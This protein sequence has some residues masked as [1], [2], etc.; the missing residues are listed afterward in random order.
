MQIHVD[1]LYQEDIILTRKAVISSIVNTLN[2]I[3]IARYVYKNYASNFYDDL[4]VGF[5]NPEFF[6]YSNSV[7]MNCEILRS[8]VSR[9]V[10]W[11]MMSI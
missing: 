4:H 2:K 5:Y 9:Q 1:N 3:T 6:L 8:S 10:I 11:A 7:L